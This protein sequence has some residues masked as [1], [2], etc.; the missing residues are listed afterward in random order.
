MVKRIL[1]LNFLFILAV[2]G[3][4]VGCAKKM[5]EQSIIPAFQAPANETKVN[6]IRATALKETAMT[7]GAQGAL[8]WRSQEINKMLELNELSLEK[9]FNFR[10]LLL[11]DNV[12]PPVLSEGR[13]ELNIADPNTLRLADHIYKIESPPRFVTAPPTWRDY[14]WTN[15]GKP[16]K[17]DSS[18][19]PKT[20]DERDLWNE[21]IKIGW[22][23]GVQQANQIFSA[24]LGRLKRDY[25][26][27]ILYRKLLAE[28]MVT[29]P[30]VAKTDMGVTGDENEMRVN[31]QIL[32]ITA[33]SKLITNSHKWKPA[34]TPGIDLG[35][36]PE[37][38]GYDR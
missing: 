11:K 8:A 28:N 3:T 16:E 10:Q 35:F 18:L 30:F 12:L 17:P 5:P 34:V 13:N 29:A 14:L 6:P 25:A 37:D 22:A 33:T 24:N 1:L 31:D 32:R 9:T 36:D 38:I 20:Q 7:L 23:D 21:Y 2:S 15:F 4:L 19:L 27:M 26:G